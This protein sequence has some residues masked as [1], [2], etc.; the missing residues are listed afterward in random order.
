MNIFTKLFL[1]VTISTLIACGGAE[2][3][4]AV[5][6]EKA[7]SSIADGDFD[8]ARIELKNVLQIDPKDAEAYY[9]LGRVF[10]S[11]KNY[12]KAF[13]NYSKAAELSPD[14]LANQ[15]RL[16]RIYLLLVNDVDKAQ[17]KVD[18]ILTKDP[19]NPEGLLL[20]AAI[21]AKAGKADEAIDVANNVLRNNPDD[22]DAISF[23]TVMY[24]KNKDTSAAK[25]LLQ[26]SLKTRPDDDAL[27]DMLAKVYL[28]EKR[29]DDVEPIYKRFL[30]KYPDEFLSYQRLAS[31]YHLEDKKLEAEK[32]LREAIRNN[33]E[34]NARYLALV[35][36]INA[37]KGQEVAIQELEK[38]VGDRTGQGDLRLALGELYLL[39]GEE[40]KAIMVYKNAI[41]DFPG[42]VTAIK[43]AISLASIYFNNG[44]TEMAES[45]VEDALQSSP[46]DPEL[47][48]LNARLALKNKNTE[49][50]IISLRLTI[51]EQPENIDAYLLLRNAYLLEGNQEQVDKVLISA[52]DNNKS[53]PAALLKLAKYYINRDLEKAEKIIDV[54][55]GLKPDD[56]EGLSIKSAIL[57]TRK[58]ADKASDIAEKLLKLYPS[59]PN[60]YLQSVPV[61]VSKGEIDKA[62]SLLQQG[63][64]KV[65]DNRKILVLLSTLEASE[66][67]FDEAE[68]RIINELKQKPDDA[69][70]KLLLAKV[71]L[72]AGK[73]E[74]AEKL[75]KE[76]LDA[77]PGA[78]E[79][80][81]L[82]AR[83]YQNQNNMS[84]YRKV[85]EKGW[86]NVKTGYRIPLKLATLYE[87]EGRYQDAIEIYREMYSLNPNNLVVINNL[88]SLLSDF[89]TKQ[90]DMD[91]IKALADRLEESGKPVFKDTIGWVYYKLGDYRKAVEYLTDVVSKAPDVNIFNYHLG[92]AYKMNGDAEKA[93]TYLSKSL[94]DGKR[95]NGY[96]DAR[97]ALKEL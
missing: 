62:I 40:S 55:N 49:K 37:T 17:E 77:N 43:S 78:E 63:Y 60:G 51:K 80:Y 72:P 69:G 3:R 74:S 58:E 66:K 86:S 89:S 27:N 39:A 6:M 41:K 83:I 56:Y 21:L 73:I 54:Y 64:D 14:H 91:L 18:F 57:N 88:A 50:A 2:E 26:K 12:Q 46:N 15:A 90:E 92:M 32:V 23:V 4:K 28:M 10:E 95:F 33:P 75:L 45:V 84:A 44:E 13:A 81:L 59:Q 16:G 30:E 67:K 5:Y 96:D 29:Y 8:K 65:M 42:E 48:F 97:K 35:K 34:D 36:Y 52:F 19:Q 82:L 93:R 87:N 68:A 1:A 7:K 53:N 85:L 94:K 20:K 61:L 22:F 25:D 76:V 31:L 70:L 47:N 11:L 38:I 24:L 71:Y 9:Q 79:P